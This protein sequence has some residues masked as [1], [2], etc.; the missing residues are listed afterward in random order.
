MRFLSLL[1]KKVK[2]LWLRIF[3]TWWYG[4]GK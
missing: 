4:A 2:L 3:G 1:I